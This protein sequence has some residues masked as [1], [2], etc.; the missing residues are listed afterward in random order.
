[1]L[2][3]IC[4]TVS[5]V[6]GQTEAISQTTAAQCVK[7]GRISSHHSTHNTHAHALLHTSHECITEP[8]AGCE[9]RSH[10]EVLHVWLVEKLHHISVRSASVESM[11]FLPGF[12]LSDMAFCH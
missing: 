10:T 12:L 5:T 6:K 3:L 9:D 4:S 2:I 11:N 7:K 1:M 8:K